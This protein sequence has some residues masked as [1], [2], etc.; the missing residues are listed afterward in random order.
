[1]KQISKNEKCDFHKN[2]HNNNF[3]Y[4]SL[5]YNRNKAK[6]VFPQSIMY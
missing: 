4:F 5:A 3:Y 6:I 2:I 1:M